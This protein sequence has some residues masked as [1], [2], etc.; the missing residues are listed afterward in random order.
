MPQPRKKGFTD[1]FE[2]AVK[3][4][5]RGLWTGGIES[6]AWPIRTFK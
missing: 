4:A 2:T 5:I 6:G 1:L 3:E